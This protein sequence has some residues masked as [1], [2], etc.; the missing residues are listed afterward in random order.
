MSN[1]SL[2]QIISLSLYR[3]LHIEIPQDKIQVLYLDQKIFQQK[4]DNLKETK[5]FWLPGCLIYL[6]FQ[7]FIERLFVVVG[8]LTCSIS[9][10]R[11]QYR[12]Q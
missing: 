2:L 12:G 7:L 8:E 1:K 10:W 6:N 3:H 11:W 4:V 9:M 5:D